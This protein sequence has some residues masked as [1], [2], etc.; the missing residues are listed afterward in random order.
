MNASSR[1]TGHADSAIGWYGKLPTAGD[2]LSRRLPGSFVQTWDHWL[3]RGL[4]QG[5][6]RFGPQWQELYL[7]FPVWRF[8]L[9]P[10]AVDGQAWCGTLLPSIDRVGRCFPLTICRPLE[11]HQRPGLIA[12]DRE[13]EAF[14]RA[15]LEGVD[16]ASIEDFDK[17]VCAIVPGA[18]AVGDTVP[19]LEEFTDRFASGQWRLHAPLDAVL[20]Q[21]AERLI[22]ACLGRRSLWWIP[23]AD[24]S[25]GTMRLE[26]L[27]L[28]PELV[29]LLIAH[30]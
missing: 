9:P 22:Q 8:L 28:A 20:M 5:R 12:L 17:L 26:N 16:G 25:A 19:A 29:P 27:P 6:D 30:E 23:A 14:A 3:Q 2:F 4:A 10:G 24:G 21:S 7:T 11:S 18:D 1:T 13:L 15:G